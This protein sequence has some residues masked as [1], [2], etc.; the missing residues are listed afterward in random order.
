VALTFDQNLRPGTARRL[1]RHSTACGDTGYGNA[2]NVHFVARLERAGQRRFQSRTGLAQR[3]GIAG[4]AV[5]P[6]REMADKV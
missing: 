2:L 6:A 1:R 5:I 4:K 3:C